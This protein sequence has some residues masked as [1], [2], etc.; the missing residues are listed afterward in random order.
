M[1]A[2]RLYYVSKHLSLIWHEIASGRRAPRCPWSSQS[3]RQLVWWQLR[4]RYDESAPVWPCHCPRHRPSCRSVPPSVR[5]FHCRPALAELSQQLDARPVRIVR[6]ERA[7]HSN[8][9]TNRHLTT[10]AI[11]NDD[12]YCEIRMPSSVIPFV[13]AARYLSS[14]PVSSR[15]MTISNF[16]RTF[17][18]NDRHTS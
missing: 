5:Q 11:N 6:S 14:F 10:T 9:T 8:A 12:C 13:F 4:V 17:S 1:H 15:Q 16:Q 7:R 3:V 18:S 2:Y